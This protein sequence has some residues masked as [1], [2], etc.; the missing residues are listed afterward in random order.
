MILGQ[1]QP[2]LRCLVK[3]KIIDDIGCEHSFDAELDTGFDG[4]VA[5]P[6]TEFVSLN[7]A[8]D[9]EN[10]IVVLADGTRRSVPFCTAKVRLGEGEQEADILNFANAK[11]PLLG[12]RILLGHEITITAV[13]FGDI[14]ILALD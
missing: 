10:K 8:S 3:I 11:Q 5:L 12:M 1:L 2:D 7:S 6:N 4:D 13:P 9:D 14:K